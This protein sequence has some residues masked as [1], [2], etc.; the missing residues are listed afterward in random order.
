MIAMILFD[1]L[2]NPFVYLEV[3]IVGALVWTL[4]GFP[5]FWTR[6]FWVRKS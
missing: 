5:E 1:L 4:A 3:L 6:K 2:T